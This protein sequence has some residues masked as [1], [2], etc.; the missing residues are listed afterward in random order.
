MGTVCFGVC[1]YVICM[2]VCMFWCIGE[3][4]EEY[5]TIKAHFAVVTATMV[6]L[7]ASSVTPVNLKKHSNPLSMWTERIFNQFSDLHVRYYYLTVPCVTLSSLYNK[8]LVY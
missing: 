6:D 4:T 8:Y 7:P 1:W 2:H 3:Y 5:Y